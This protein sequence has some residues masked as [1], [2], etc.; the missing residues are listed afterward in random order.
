M[1]KILSIILALALLLVMVAA[2]TND[3]PAPTPSPTPTDSGSGDDP[4]PDTPPPPDGPK[5]DKF[6]W[7]DFVGYDP[8]DP[9]TGDFAVASTG[10][11]RWWANLYNLRAGIDN[12]ILQLDFRPTPFDSRDYDDVNQYFESAG[13]WMGNWGE[14]I[15][16][17]AM[18]GI[19][20]CAYLTFRMRGAVGGEEYA[21]MLHFQPEDGPSYVARFADLKTADGD[22]VEITTDMQDIVIDLAASGFPGMT[23]RMH[24]RAFLA[25]TIFIEEIYFSNPVGGLDPDDPVSSMPPEIGAPTSLPIRHWATF[26]WNDF[27]GYD[28]SDV[29]TG[30]FALVT[31]GIARWWANLYNLDASMDGGALRIEFEPAV[32]DADDVSW[33]GNW[34]EAINMWALPGISYCKYFVIRMAGAAGGEEDSLI[35]HFQPEDGPSYVA[36]F[37][38]LVTADGGNVVITTDMQDI[39]IDLEASG[40]AGMTNRMHIRAFKPC[41]I[42]IDELYFFSA[43]GL[44]DSDNPL[45]GMP[46]EIGPLGDLPIADWR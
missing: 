33:M 38:D 1:K 15:N 27:N 25:A 17:W 24:I 36:R 39:I 3:D 18:E 31:T 14:A 35:L 43:V 13:D 19:D 23:N 32:F 37:A 22:F 42:I 44:I 30:D 46:P 45:A 8:S 40:F 11:A 5:P 26:I 6:I 9:A 41:T 12:D 29:A 7:N 2:C 21:M 16:M 4:T 34:G 10:M 20:N 28:P